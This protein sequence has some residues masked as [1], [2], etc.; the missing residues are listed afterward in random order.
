MLGL[1][2]SLTSTKRRYGGLM[3]P[4]IESPKPQNL[5]DL[6]SN[7]DDSVDGDGAIEATAQSPVT[8][9]TSQPASGPIRGVTMGHD[10]TPGG[11]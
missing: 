2:E 7:L 4:A 1:F 8:G 11:G 3:N 5:D 10:G 6:S 9:A